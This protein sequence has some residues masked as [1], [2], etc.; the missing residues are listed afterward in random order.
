[1]PESPSSNPQ[2]VQ[3]SRQRGMLPPFMVE[4]LVPALKVG[5]MTGKLLS[6]N[7]TITLFSDIPNIV[8]GGVGVV[9]GVAAGIVKDVYPA[10]FG[11]ASGIQ[12]FTLGS[13]FW[14]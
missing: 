4:L 12:C 6:I 10:L 14:R 5:T 8:A 7:E 3:P 13:S 9:T 2:D 11:L 1:M